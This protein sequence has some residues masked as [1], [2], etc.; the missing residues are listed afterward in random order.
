MEIGAITGYIDVAQIV[1]Y[2]FWIFFAYLIWYLHG[3]NK[4]EGYP[5]VSDLTERTS[6]VSP[7]GFPAIPSPKTFN[8]AD[9]SSIQMP[10]F[11]GDA[12]SLA[13]APAAPHPGAAFEPTGNPMHDGV[14]P[15]SWSE[16]KDVPDLTVHGTPKL[17]PM[18]LAEGFHVAEED[19]DPRGMTVVGA[20]G[21]EAGKVSEVWVDRAEYLIRYL[22]VDVTGTGSRLLPMTMLRIND[23]R[24][25][26]TVRSILGAQFAGVPAH[27]SPDQVTR[28]EEDKISAYYAGGTL[29]ATPARAE[30]IL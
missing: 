26:V 27:A 11:R 23:K 22:E 7:Q 9:G 2:V 28:L 12:R 4:R 25:L 13:M 29:Y 14:G 10:D 6:R 18:R 21:V 24:G 15:A 3:E 20:D 16:R 5:L 19:P 8:L 30:P 17:V 1:L